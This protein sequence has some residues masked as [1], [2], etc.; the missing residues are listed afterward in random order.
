VVRERLAVIE[1]DVKGLGTW[2]RNILRSIYGP[3]REQGMWG[4]R[5]NQK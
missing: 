4:I 3:V 2:E 1:M 5:T